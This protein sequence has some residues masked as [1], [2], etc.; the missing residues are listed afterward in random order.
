MKVKVVHVITGLGDGGAEAVMARLC[1]HNSGFEHVVIS[2]QGEGKYGKVLEEFGIK[3]HFLNLGSNPKSYLNLLK[4][5]NLLKQEKPDIV[6]TWMY[7]ADLFGGLAAKWVGVRRIAWGIRHSTLDRES[8]KLSTIGIAYLCALLSRRIP[9]VIICCANKALQSHVDIG[10]DPTRMVIIKN[11]YDLSR[12]YPDLSQRLAMRKALSIGKT[13]FVLG[14]VS[15]FDRNKDHNNLLKAL[16]ILRRANLDFICL[17]VGSDVVKENNILYQSIADLDL[18]ENI[19]LLGPRNDIPAIMNSLDAHVL[20]SR[21]EGF[22]NVVAEAMACGIVCIS[23]DV[24]D[25]SEIVDS[26]ESICAPEDPY[27]LADAVLKVAGEWRKGG[28][29]W[30][31]RKKSCSSKIKAKFDLASMVEAYER[32]WL[33]S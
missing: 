22:P 6:Q 18:K 33:S 11:G 8:T 15:R 9:H 16:S 30:Q 13:V 27:A 1:M 19:M 21:S 12:F 28:K 20:S 17:L 4:L 10:Y 24:G 2:L 26:P 29:M 25:A 5:P 3:L 23:T 31:Q 32:A 7:H 14:N